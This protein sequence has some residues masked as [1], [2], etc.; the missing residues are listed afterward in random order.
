MRTADLGR[1]LRIIVNGVLFCG[2]LCASALTGCGSSSEASE[3][4]DSGA[5]A[6]TDTESDPSTDEPKAQ[7]FDAAFAV[8][9]KICRECHKP[10]TGH[11]FIVE[12]TAEAT[13][14]SASAAKDRIEMRINAELETERMPPEMPLAA[15]DLR[16]L[17][18]WLA[19]L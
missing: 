4:V 13:L 18:D 9:A 14:P 15:D 2:V 3:D 19:S 5:E 6:T 12:E 17:N 7:E 1:D 11:S 10:G 8:M 16:A